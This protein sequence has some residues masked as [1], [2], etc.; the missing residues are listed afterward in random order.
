MIETPRGNRV[1]IA[2]FGKTN[3]GKSTLINGITG[4]NISL[5]SDVRGTTTDPVY[6]AMELLPI[7]PVVFIDTAGIDDDTTIGNLRVE[8]TIEVLNKMDIALLVISAKDVMDNNLDIEKGWF[9]RIKSKKKPCIV[10]INKADLVKD[11]KEF[12]KRLEDLEKSWK[13]KTLSISSL[14]KEDMTR[15]K[16]EIIKLAPE[17]APEPSL[18]GDRIKLGDRVL[19]VAPQD[20]QAPKGR[21]ILP[22]VQVLRDILDHGGIPAMVTLEN[23][24]RGLEIFGGKPDLVIT[25]SQIFKAVDKVVDKDVPLTSFSIIMARAKGDLEIFYR[26]AK[27]I[28]NLKPG[29]RVLIAEA[30]THH[31]MKGDI[32]R[33][34]IPMLLEKKIP[35]VVIENCSGKDFPKDLSDFSLV[36]HCGSCMLNRAETMSRVGDCRDKNL[37]ITNFGMAIAQINGILDRVIDIFNI[38]I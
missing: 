4:Q 27:Q 10:I 21:L 11:E 13:V 2:L 5:V 16:E 36:I 34:K 31:Q 17:L 29:D 37:H 6:K 33:E 28:E 15:V 18:I 12:E 7:G 35:G 1:H 26:G 32:A 19:L 8:K 30:C 25:D 38:K 23:L 14:K 20:I 9:E 22:Q 24:E 3:A